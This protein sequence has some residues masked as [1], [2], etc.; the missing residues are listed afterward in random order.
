MDVNFPQYFARSIAPKALLKIST[1]RKS[2]TPTIVRENG[3][4]ALPLIAFMNP[5]TAREYVQL[6]ANC[7]ENFPVDQFGVVRDCIIPN[8][9]EFLDYQEPRTVELAC[10]SLSRLVESFRNHKEELEV[11]DLFKKNKKK[12]TNGLEFVSYEVFEHQNIASDLVIRKLIN[13][14][15]PGNAGTIRFVVNLR[16][17]LR[18]RSDCGFIVIAL[19]RTSIYGECLT[20]SHA[21][22]HGLLRSCCGTTRASSIVCMKLLPDVFLAQSMLH[23][24]YPRIR[25]SC[26]KSLAW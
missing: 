19:Q 11:G 22:L 15:S 26:V 25:T 12:R 17:E 7:S 14:L 9:P 6:L 1:V 21:S 24:A 13:I 18:I 20:F 3:L 4:Q 16:R 2:C 8:I 10:L 23:C 5:A